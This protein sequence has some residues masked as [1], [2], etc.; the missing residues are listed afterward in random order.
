MR[1]GR[2]ATATSNRTTSRSGQPGVRLRCPDVRQEP[3][4][5]PP[6]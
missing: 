4:T 3:G 2:W 5:Q 1:C 6:A